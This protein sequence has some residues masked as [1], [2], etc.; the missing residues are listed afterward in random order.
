MASQPGLIAEARVQTALRKLRPC[1]PWAASVND[2]AAGMGALVVSLGRR[3][4][5]AIRPPLGVAVTIAMLLAGCSGGGTTAGSTVPATSLPS[6]TIEPATTNEPATT[7]LP[8]TTNSTTPVATTLSTVLAA[9]DTP[10]CTTAQLGIGLKDGS[11][12]AGHAGLILLFE[13][14]GSRCALRGYPGVAGVDAAG[15]VTVQAERTPN[16]YLGGIGSATESTVD[17]LKGQSASAL[18]EGLLGPSSGGPPCQSYTAM[19]ITPPNET[20]SVSVPV[21]FSLCYPEVHPI[22]SGSAG[23]AS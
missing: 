14:T 15:N 4:G 12:G 17:L 13:N 16:G 22:V 1:V 21:S 6:T 23:G 2:A 7:R 5:Y 10:T 9:P 8:I 19:L 18:L 3:R 11:A 20:N